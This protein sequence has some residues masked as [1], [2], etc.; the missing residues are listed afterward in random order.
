MYQTKK[1]KA[2]LLEKET[3]YCH[4]IFEQSTVIPQGGVCV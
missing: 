4:D 3:S 2:K 1:K